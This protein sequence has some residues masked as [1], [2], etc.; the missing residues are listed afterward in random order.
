M[1]VICEICSKYSLDSKQCTN[2]SSQIINSEESLTENTSNQWGW[3]TFNFSVN[4]LA[5]K[6]D[7]INYLR[8]E[9][10][11]IEKLTIFHLFNSQLSKF[12]TEVENLKILARKDFLSTIINDEYL[13]DEGLS[14][15]FEPLKITITTAEE[16]NK[17]LETCFII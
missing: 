13:K 14:V 1:K 7:I 9:W 5:K 8:N 2:C 3:A 16:A 10:S 15:N 12:N 6:E 11:L 4:N 17:L